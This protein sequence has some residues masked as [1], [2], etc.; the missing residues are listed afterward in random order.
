MSPRRSRLFSYRISRMA[1]LTKSECNPVLR[2]SSIGGRRVY[3]L[4]AGHECISGKWTHDG[5]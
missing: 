5:R 1:E 3:H 4:N 2:V